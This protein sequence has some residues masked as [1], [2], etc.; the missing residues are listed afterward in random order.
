MMMAKEKDDIRIA[1]YNAVMATYDEQHRAYKER[2][3]KSKAIYDAQIKAYDEKRAQ[4]ESTKNNFF[5]GDKPTRPRMESGWMDLSS[6]RYPRVSNDEIHKQ[7]Y[8]SIKEELTNKYNLAD[9]AI[10]PF[11]MTEGDVQR[12]IA[13]EDGSKVAALLK[14]E[15]P[16]HGCSG[17]WW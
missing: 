11:R 8:E 4:W 17:A 10:G 14:G 9:A 2:Y 6:P 7:Y 5:S 15:M 13:W 3:D 1:H 12:M 16:K